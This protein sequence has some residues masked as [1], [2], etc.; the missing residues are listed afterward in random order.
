MRHLLG[1]PKRTPRGAPAASRPERLGRHA[2]LQ[3]PLPLPLPAHLAQRRQRGRDE[4]RDGADQHGLPWLPRLRVEVEVADAT[5]E[6]PHFVA[7]CLCL[8]VAVSKKAVADTSLRT[9]GP[10]ILG[11]TWRSREILWTSHV[12]V[13][14][15][16]PPSWTLCF[17]FVSFFETAKNSCSKST[18]E[19][20]RR[21]KE[22]KKTPRR[23]RRRSLGSTTKHP[24]AR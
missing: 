3:E 8:R 5:I 14:F 1:R 22:E 19:D 9:A 10:Y 17:V 13:S 24:R 23:R 4:L 12:S 20:K 15:R 16:A 11:W 7:V 2:L 21:K 18:Q 6:R